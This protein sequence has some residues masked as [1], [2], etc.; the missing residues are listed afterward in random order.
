M[1][2]I[3]CNSKYGQ[4]LFLCHSCEP[5]MVHCTVY[6]LH[7]MRS[8]RGGI[9]GLSTTAQAAA[10]VQHTSLTIKILLV[11]SLNMKQISVKDILSA[12]DLFLTYIFKCQV[13]SQE[14]NKHIKG[15]I[16]TLK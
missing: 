14:K 12:F 3:S 4:S 11:Y 10:T 8:S 6:T 15:A 7:C 9:A 2:L 16:Q 13:Q 5:N 1:N